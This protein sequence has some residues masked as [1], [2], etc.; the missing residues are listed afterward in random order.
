MDLAEFQRL[1][2]WLADGARSAANPI[3]MMS[4]AC[5]RLVRAGVPLWRVGVFVRTL[6]PDI[7]GHSFTWRPG[8]EIVITNADFDVQD[9]DEFKRSPLFILYDTEKEVRFRLDDPASEGF[10]FFDDMR[11]EGITDYIAIPLR[12]IEG[13]IHSSSWSTKQPGGFTDEQLDL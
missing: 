2:D 1:L 8:T 5:E 13:S 6:H 3:A 7:F 10:P 4:E 11:A 9:S 12:Y